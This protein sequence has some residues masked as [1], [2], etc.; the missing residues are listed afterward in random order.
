M[1][2]VTCVIMLNLFLLV[3]L[4]QY[5]DFYKKKE[6]PIE[7][8]N[9]ILDAFKKSWNKYST[10]SDNGYRIN[11]NQISNFL[12]ELDSEIV[13]NLPKRIDHVKKYILDLRLLK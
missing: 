12:M 10:E 2:F 4:Q 5:D 1:N 6:N 13:T 8:F 7:K 11:I 3:T 9:D